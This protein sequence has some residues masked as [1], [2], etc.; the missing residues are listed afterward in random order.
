MSIRIDLTLDCADPTALAEF[1]KLALGYIEEPPPTPFATRAEWLDSLDLEPAEREGDAAWL[2]DPTGA[3]PRLF[4]I[5]VPEPKTV[6]NR[7]HM[8][9]RVSGEDGTR[10]ERWARVTATAERL[11]AAG[12]TVLHSYDGA[13]LIMA[14][15]ESHEFCLA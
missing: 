4:L 12:A 11:I 7:L 13:H 2:C 14:D 15:P 10:A 8:D 5:Q 1:W 3:G 9:V 6:K